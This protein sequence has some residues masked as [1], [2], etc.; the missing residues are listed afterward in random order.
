MTFFRVTGANKATGEDVS[1]VVEAVAAE[2]AEQVGIGR[3]LFVSDVTEIA[4]PMVLDNVTVAPPPPPPLSS[5]PEMTDKDCAVATVRKWHLTICHDLCLPYVPVIVRG[6]HREGLA[7]RAFYN[8]TQNESGF[9]AINFNG[10]I[11]GGPVGGE[12]SETYR[13]E[14]YEVPHYTER[15]YIRSLAHELRHIW[16]YI[17]R[18]P[19]TEEDCNDYSAR[20]LN[21]FSQPDCGLCPYWVGEEEWIKGEAAALRT[22]EAARKEGRMGILSLLCVAAL[23][24]GLICILAGIFLYYGNGC[25]MA[26]WGCNGSADP[27]GPVGLAC[28]GAACL[29]VAGVTGA[30]WAVGRRRLGSRTVDAQARAAA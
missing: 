1:L 27:S 15:D 20:V 6:R 17:N 16:Q 24:L 7:G 12:V 9:L 25:Q 23:A 26:Y 30:I 4:P 2:V 14:I 5:R 22:R 8:W 18:V 10:L 28:F 19:P 29:V 21:R 13:V 3:G 11:V